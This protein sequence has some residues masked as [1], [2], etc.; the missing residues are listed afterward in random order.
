MEVDVIQICKWCHNWPMIDNSYPCTFCRPYKM[1]MIKEKKKNACIYCN[2]L[3]LSGRSI[4][5]SCKASSKERWDEIKMKNLCSIK[6]ANWYDRF[7][8]EYA[9]DHHYNVILSEV[10]KTTI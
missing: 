10:M 7:H 2:T 9:N 1:P 8:A 4:C 5:N 3:L 6:T